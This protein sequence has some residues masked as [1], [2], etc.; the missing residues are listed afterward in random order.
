MSAAAFLNSSLAPAMQR[1]V[2][3]E[4]NDG[5]SGLLYLAPERLYAPNF[6]AGLHSFAEKA[7][8][9]CG[10]GSRSQAD[11]IAI[12]HEAH[13]SARS[14]FFFPVIVIGHAGQSSSRPIL[15]RVRRLRTT[16]EQIFLEYHARSPRSSGR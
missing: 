9:V 12:M 4:L 16:G 2:V 14:G 3:A 5:F 11:D 13:A 1:Q 6:Q 8:Q 15:Y 10:S 7:N